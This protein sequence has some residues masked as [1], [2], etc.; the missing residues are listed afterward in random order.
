[1]IPA[2]DSPKARTVQFTG[3]GLWTCRTCAGM[4]ALVLAGLSAVANCFF[5]PCVEF[6]AIRREGRIVAASRHRRGPLQRVLSHRGAGRHVGGIDRQGRVHHAGPRFVGHEPR[7]ALA[8]ARRPWFEP[9]MDD[10]KDPDFRAFVIVVRAPP[11]C[12]ALAT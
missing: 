5:L 3:A 12:E 1:M 4:T 9:G 6:L 2:D 10:V 8:S 7:A 11:L